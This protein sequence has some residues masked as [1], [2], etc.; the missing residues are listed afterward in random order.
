MVVYDS[1]WSDEWN[2]NGSYHASFILG[3]KNEYGKNEGS[4]GSPKNPFDHFSGDPELQEI[5]VSFGIVRLWSGGPPTFRNRS[6]NIV[7][8]SFHP[9]HLNIPVSYLYLFKQARLA[10]NVIWLEDGGRARGKTYTVPSIVIRKRWDVSISVGVK[11]NAH[12]ARLMQMLCVRV[13]RISDAL[14]FKH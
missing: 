4:I 9:L 5:S 12:I 2:W 1:G 13:L 14:Y 6:V 11:N 8:W 7:A 10:L 3:C